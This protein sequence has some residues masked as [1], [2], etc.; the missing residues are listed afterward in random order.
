MFLQV[1]A[2]GSARRQS[3]LDALAQETAQRDR[4]NADLRAAQE[5]LNK[6][7]ATAPM[8]Q[9]QANAYEKLVKDGF[10]SPL[11]VQD[12]R[13]EAINLQQDLK[14]QAAAV[15]SLEAQLASQ[16]KKIANLTSQYRSQLQNAP[17]R[18]ATFTRR[19]LCDPIWTFILGESSHSAPTQAPPLFVLLCS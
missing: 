2:Q 17:G 15:A 8:V 14:S 5:T 10:F 3:Y 7:Q 18:V 11:A 1:Q 19:T 13:R 9:Q 4:L 6:L 16:N 12:K